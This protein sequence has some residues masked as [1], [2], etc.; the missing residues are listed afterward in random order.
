VSFPSFLHSGANDCRRF[1]QPWLFQDL[2]NVVFVK[3]LSPKAA[4][5]RFFSV[6][7]FLVLARP[8]TKLRTT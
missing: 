8:T 6:A 3:D 2:V 1:C 7:L 5:V 4:E